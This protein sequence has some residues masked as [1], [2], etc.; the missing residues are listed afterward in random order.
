MQAS[1][2]LILLVLASLLYSPALPAAETSRPSGDS[3]PV[4]GME[5]YVPMLVEILKQIG[6][7]RLEEAFDLY[8]KQ[9]VR[10]LPTGEGPFAADNKARFVGVFKPF[11]NGVEMESIDFVAARRLSTRAWELLLIAN[12][13]EGPVA[14]QFDVFR[15]DNRWR[16]YGMH[17]TVLWADSSKTT[18]SKYHT[19]YQW[20][21]EP[22]TY[23][24]R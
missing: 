8:E 21:A 20:F 15:F 4:E 12:T 5:D 11:E 9:L 14:F 16:L 23:R 13:G 6:P 3:F 18:Q 2:R 7:G 22:V 17:F 24:A 1:I 19:G 10:P